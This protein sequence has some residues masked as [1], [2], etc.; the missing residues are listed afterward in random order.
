MPAQCGAMPPITASPRPRNTHTHTP[1]IQVY[2]QTH[3]MHSMHTCT[4][5]HTCT[6]LLN[7]HSHTHSHFVLRIIEEN[8]HIVSIKDVSLPENTDY[9]IMKTFCNSQY[10]KPVKN[11][12]AV[13]ELL[14]CIQLN[15]LWKE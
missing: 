12:G 9:C 1:C 11:K 15:Y 5:T 8:M 7:I 6:H 10:L 13:L 4:N 14:V 2:T 3:Q